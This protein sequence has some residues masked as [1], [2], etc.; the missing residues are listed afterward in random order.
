MKNVYYF[1]KPSEFE[2]L[3]DIDIDGNV[4][5]EVCSDF[6][7]LSD[8]K[9]NTLIFVGRV[10][11]S[12]RVPRYVTELVSGERFDV[13]LLKNKKD[14]NITNLSLSS[15]TLGLYMRRGLPINLVRHEGIEATG[16]I[17]SITDVEEK[18]KA[19]C[20]QIKAMFDEASSYKYSYD[21]AVKGPSKYM[22]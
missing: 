8:D 10:S 16:L 21:E 6:E 18:E 3:D 13:T 7:G 17:Y 4:A 1:I 9:E 20:G 15:D 19:Y 11:S 14:P 2:R 22:R 5:Y 12:D